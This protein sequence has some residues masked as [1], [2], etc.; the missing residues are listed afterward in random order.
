MGSGIAATRLTDDVGVQ[1]L[2]N[3]FATAGALVA[4]IL[5]VGP[6]SGAHLN[7]VVSVVDRVLGGITWS[8]TAVYAAA[9]VAG[10]CLGAVLANLMY[11]L[12][13][14]ELSTR[15]RGG[16]GVLLAEAVATLGL[17]LVVFGVARS[18][19]AAV[20]PIAVAAY[21]GSAYFATSSTSFANPAVTVGRTLTDSFAGI[22]PASAPAFLAF[23]L[24]GGAAGL[25]LVRLLHPDVPA[26]D[27]V[28]PHD[29]SET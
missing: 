22:A 29:G 3:A 28:V 25:G 12:P 15:D 17:L 16:P 8:E 13:A 10:A 11:E 1:L 2:V 14:V 19:R 20:A 6:V 9:Q 27:V 7:P 5:A 26:R 21:I 24:V 23:Q 18:G 4:V